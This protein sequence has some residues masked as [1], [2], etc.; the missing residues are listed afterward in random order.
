M[1]F[2]KTNI[3]QNF[4]FINYFLFPKE[5]TYENFYAEN[6]TSQRVSFLQ[7]TQF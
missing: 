7:N 4:M 1:I 6:F 2:L 3:K 5:N